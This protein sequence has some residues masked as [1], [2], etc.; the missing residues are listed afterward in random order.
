VAIFAER[1]THAARL[2]GEQDMTRQDAINF[3]IHGVAN[4]GGDKLDGILV[5]AAL[6]F[7]KRADSKAWPAV[8]RLREAS[9]GCAGRCVRRFRQCRC[10]RARRR[11]LSSAVAVP[12]RLHVGVGNYTAGVQVVETFADEATLVVGETVDAVAG[13]GDLLEDARGITLAFVREQPY[14]LDGLFENLDHAGML[15]ARLAFAG[16]RR[17]GAAHHAFQRFWRDLA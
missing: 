14:A 11:Q 5:P 13:I 2:L 6:A 4:G 15:S 7:T 17:G 1:Q 9:G 16:S 10:G 3:I 8:K 12:E